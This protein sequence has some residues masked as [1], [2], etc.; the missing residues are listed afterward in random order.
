MRWMYRYIDDRKDEIDIQMGWMYR[1][2]DDGKD[3]KGGIIII[4]IIKMG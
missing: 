3:E 1:Y 2:I 4:I